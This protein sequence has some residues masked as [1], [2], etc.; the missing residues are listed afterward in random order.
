MLGDGSLA[1]QGDSPRARYTEGAKN[2]PYLRWK[3]EI[4][5]DYFPVHVWRRRSR[6]SDLTGKR[7]LCHFLKT[8]VHPFL[9]DWHALWYGTRKVVPVAVIREHLTPFA[10]AVWFCDDGHMAKHGAFLYTMAFSTSEV[11]ALA[12]LLERR[13]ALPAS[14]L[15]KRGDQPYLRFPARVL[16]T[17]KDLLASFDLPGMS[18][19][20]R[21]P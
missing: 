17:I 3:A 19:K 10:F 1:R 16:P 14:I 9:G 13:F 6:P 7:H 4:L 2:L 8:G 20:Y 11:R 15:Y 21:G 18:Y 12:E 5:R